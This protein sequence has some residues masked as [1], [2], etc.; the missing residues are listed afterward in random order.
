MIPVASPG[1]QVYGFSGG[2]AKGESVSVTLHRLCTDNLQ[3]PSKFGG[4]YYLVSHLCACRL[5]HSHEISLTLSCWTIGKYTVTLIPGDGI[6]KEVA[7]S[8]KEIFEALKVPVQWEQY[9]VLGETTGG[10]ELFQ[11]AMQSLKRNKVGLKGECGSLVL[12]FDLTFDW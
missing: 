3:L 12:G 6:G 1:R 8:V 7:D 5:V 2:R 10:D 11:E 9:D 4:V